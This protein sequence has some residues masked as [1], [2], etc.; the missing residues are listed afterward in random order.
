MWSQ[1]NVGGGVPQRQL[2]DRCSRRGRTELC[3]SESGTSEHKGETVYAPGPATS[4][5]RG[6]AAWC[7][8]IASPRRRLGLRRWGRTKVDPGGDWR[9]RPV[10]RS[11]DRLCWQLELWRVSARLVVA[12][13]VAHCAV[14]EE[15]RSTIA[16]RQL[17]VTAW[18][19]PSRCTG[20]VHAEVA[21]WGVVGE[22]HT[23]T[24][25]VHFKISQW[26]LH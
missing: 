5:D 25:A 19:R 1:T 6:V 13:I 22:V 14:V 21:D 18:W 10:L 24:C 4:E 12:N 8:W 7:V 9:H 3:R 26:R 23:I 20:I 17:Y 16:Q 2:P 11:S 15:L